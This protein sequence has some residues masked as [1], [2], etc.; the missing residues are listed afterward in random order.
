[1]PQDRR[2]E[3][4]YSFIDHPTI[5]ISFNSIPPHVRAPWSDVDATDV[6]KELTVFVIPCQPG[7]A[8]IV[9]EAKAH[10]LCLRLSRAKMEALT[11]PMRGAER[12][13][14]KRWP[15]NLFQKRNFG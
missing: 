1:M 2:K 6:G 15:A 5:R 8:I 13:P 9:I 7:T 11:C 3:F 14:D 4:L 10:F 12:A